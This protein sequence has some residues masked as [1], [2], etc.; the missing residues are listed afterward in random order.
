MS[1]G[2]FSPA[3]LERRLARRR[4]GWRDLLTSTREALRSLEQSTGSDAIDRLV[5]RNLLFAYFYGCGRALDDAHYYLVRTRVPWHA[6][7]ITVRR[8]ESLNGSP[9]FTAALA[10]V[11][12]RCLA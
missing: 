6:R 2:G 4:R 12:K 1:R 3:W 5:N 8:P 10:E 11:A 9:T 7:G